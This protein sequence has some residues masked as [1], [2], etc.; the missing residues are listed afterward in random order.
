MTRAT[1]LSLL[2]ALASGGCL[3]AT[4]AF[5]CTRSTD[6]GAGG[7]CEPVG[8]C[9]FPDPSCSDGQRFGSLSGPF[10]NQCVGAGSSSGD[11]GVTGDAPTPGS[12]CW[13]AWKQ[14]TIALSAPIE[15]A[16][17]AS[18]AAQEHPSL[19]GDDLTLYF[20]RSVPGRARDFYAATRNTVGE[21]W[22]AASPISELDSTLDEERVTVSG[23]GTI[24]VLA[25]TR[26]GG[27]VDLWYATR[28]SPTGTFST[29]DQQEV[30]AVDTAAAEFDPQLSRDGLRLYLSPSTPTNGQVIAIAS[31]ATTSAAFGSA[32]MLPELSI[33]NIVAD[34]V[35]SPDEL[36]IFFSSAAGTTRSIY[37]A[38]RATTGD[39]FGTATKVPAVSS[40]AG[41]FDA[42][43]AVSSTGCEL[44]FTSTRTGTKQLFVAVAR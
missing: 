33:S 27:S 29:P 42:N 31:R 28:G 43:A 26:G 41:G 35:V 21:P 8:F 3:K 14:G 17:L 22:G 1:A 37:V 12:D 15:I 6:C 9:S 36:V 13:P 18:G 38:T 23:D 44:F 24:A 20:D 5:P 19:S 4:D 34:P 7:T 10:A 30:S 32:T 2:V 11:G 40:G 39:P 16:E 25:S